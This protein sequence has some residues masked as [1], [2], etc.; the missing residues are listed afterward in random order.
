MTWPARSWA[1]VN[2]AGACRSRVRTSNVGVDTSSRPRSAEE[3][4]IVSRTLLRYLLPL[5]V[6]LAV[7]LAAT[8]AVADDEEDDGEEQGQADGEEQEQVDGEEQGQVDGEE[9]AAEGEEGESDEDTIDRP[10]F[11]NVPGGQQVGDG[12]LPEGYVWQRE[13]HPSYR[14]DQKRDQDVASW[15]HGFTLNYPVS[16]K[17]SFSSTANINTRTNDA[18]NRLNRQETWTAGLDARVTSAITTGLKFRRN[19]HIDVQ[20][21]GKANETRS[22][23]EKESIKLST[24]YHKVYM[25]GLDVSLGATAGI[26]KN[27]YTDVKSNGG[28]QGITG[29]LG[30]SPIENL[31]TSFSYTGNHSLLDS[32]QGNLRSKDESTNHDLSGH[33]DYDWQMH[34]F[35]VDMRRSTGTQQYPKEEQTEH[36]EQENESTSVTAKLEL[37]EGL[38]AELSFDYSRKQQYYSVEPSRNNDIAARGVD[39]HITYNLGETQFKADLGSDRKRNDSFDV[40]TGDNYT[41]TL[42]ASLAHTL[43]EGLDVS[44]RGRMSL[45]SV[46][47]DDIDANDKDRDL[48]DREATFTVNYRTRKDITTGLVV[49]VRE[50]QLIYIRRSRT[51]DNKTTQK[52]AIEP[53]IR[54]SFSPRFGASQRYQL[55]ADYTFY[56]YDTDANFLIRNMS[57]TTGLNWKPFDPLELGLEHTWRVQDEGSYAENEQ[58]VEGYGRNSERIDQKLGITLGYKIADL[59]QIEVRQ[60]LGVQ[61]KWRIDEDGNK[62]AVWDKFDTSIVGKASTDYS[63]PDGT[64]LKI[65]IARTHR[66]ATSISERQREVWNISANLSRTF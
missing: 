64:A 49:R 39:A 31:S 35:A 10:E 32:E 46:H 15:T 29:N 57:V 27:R 8:P 44:L 33:V 9:Q 55:S 37:L 25:Q 5:A 26:E 47:Y 30:Y 24:S 38:G 6:L 63:L 16:P 58:G 7:V 60:N 48:F 13:F 53:F 43:K 2:V 22:A 66:N 41:N 50:D 20:N 36:R 62:T 40:R 28:T 18:S 3:E 17:I 19:K 34:H 21:E 45:L 54:K 51:G 56:Q 1:T 4:R 65:S 11:Q 12:E 42:S 52:F 61:D 59:I 23:R 14:L